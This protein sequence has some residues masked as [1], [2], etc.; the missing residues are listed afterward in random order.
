MWSVQNRII[1]IFDSSCI[2]FSERYK[3]NIHFRAIALVTRNNVDEAEDI[4]VPFMA[5]SACIQH[6]RFKWSLIGFVM[7]HYQF[8]YSEEGK[9]SHSIHRA[10]ARKLW[11]R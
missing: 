11:T 10:R 3:I 9:L 1:A 5:I 7:S 4:H 2:G 6:F 8:E